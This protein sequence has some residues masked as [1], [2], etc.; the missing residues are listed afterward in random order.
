MAALEVRD[1]RKR[2]G[3]VVALDGVDLTVAQG[4]VFCLLGPNGAGKST[5]TEILEGYRVCDGGRVSVLGCDPARGGSALRERVGI[6]LQEC[7]IQPDLT[8]TELIEMYGSYYARRRPVGE[9][10]GLVD[11]TASR[12]T[13]AGKLSGGQRRRLDLAIGLVGDPDVLFLDEPTTG[14]D[15][16]ARRHAWSTIRNLCDL[17]KTVFL[18]THFMDEAQ[19]L[20]DRI[21]VLNAGRI[22]AVGTPAEIGG[23]SEASTEIS[24]ALPEGL[25]ISDLPAFG[26]R[27]RLDGHEVVFYARDAVDMLHRLTGWALDS[28]CELRGLT[29]GQP[30][31]EDIYLGLTHDA[32]TESVA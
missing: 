28:G 29:V 21:A 12:D 32:A 9:L 16:A 23:R 6:V 15:P 22:V 24:F 11:L 8:V 25:S 5:L 26:D 4:E 18:T 7:G 27:L 31:L 13:R 19:A 14:F 2:Y 3:D 30:S 17:G 10:L 1:V 20:A